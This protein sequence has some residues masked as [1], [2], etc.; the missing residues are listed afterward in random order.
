MK[1]HIKDYNG[2]AKDVSDFVVNYL[3]K[4][5]DGRVVPI[6][7]EKG[8]LHFPPGRR[9]FGAIYDIIS[10]YYP[11]ETKESFAKKFVNIIINSDIGF[12][13][14]RDVKKIVYRVYPASI[15]MKIEY[16][17]IQPLYDISFPE[18]LNLA[19][20]S[21]EVY[22]NSIDKRRFFYRVCND[23]HEGLWY[24]KNGNH[25]GL[26][27]NQYS[28]CKN[29]NLEMHFDEELI[30]YLSVADSLEHLYEWFPIK[31]LKKLKLHGY[32]ISKFVSFDYKKYDKF[33]HTIINKDSSLLVK[34]SKYNHERSET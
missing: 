22:R 9:S 16:I 3:F 24:D 11:E 15:A 25:T 12:Y 8:N 27:H 1:L 6:F 18:L 4:G 10:S 32:Y 13:H 14:C 20:M 26:I 30:G 28:F 31:D 5:C 21:K 17:D 7:D 19:D 34:K 2:E 23:N 33:N 29:S